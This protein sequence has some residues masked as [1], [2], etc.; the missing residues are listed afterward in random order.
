LIYPNQFSPEIENNTFSVWRPIG[1]SV[2]PIGLS[3]RP[4]GLS[5]RPIGLSGEN[6]NNA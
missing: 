2:R 3:V 5:A 1:L 4:I 6:E